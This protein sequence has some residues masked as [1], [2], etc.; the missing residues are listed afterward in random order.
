MAVSEETLPAGPSLHVPRPGRL[1]L[2]FVVAG[3][4]GAGMVV[5]AAVAYHESLAGRIL[6]GISVAGADV[7]GL[8]PDAATSLLNDRLRSLG[9]GELVIRTPDGSTTLPFAAVS[10]AA[11]VETMVAEAVA[12]GRGGTWLD[13]TVAAVRTSLEPRTIDL[14][15]GF[16]PQGVS[17]AVRAFAAAMT[18]APVDAQ[19]VKTATAFVVVPSVDGREI[20]VATTTAAVDAALAN[21]TT[22]SGFVIEAPVRTSLPRLSTA[23]AEAARDAAGRIVGTHLQ[24]RSGTKTWTLYGGRIRTWLEFGWVDGAYGPTIDQTLIPK[25]FATIGK[26]VARPVHDAALLRDKH[27]RVVGAE[28]DSAG[29]ELDVPGAVSAVVQALDDRAEGTAAATVELPLRLLVPATRTADVTRHAPLMVRVG[30]WTTYYQVSDHNGF[31]ANITVPTRTLNG[32]VV[33]PGEVFDFWRALGEV[34]FRTGYRLGGAIVGGHSVEGK[35]LA[36]GICAASTT[37]FNAALRGGYEI[38]ARQPHWYYITRYP[39]GL[40]A[41][42]SGSQTMRFRNDTRY[43]ILIRGFTGPGVVRFEI[44]SVPNGRTVTLTRPIVTNLV[45]GYDTT[46]RTATLPKGTTKRTE[47]PVDGKD[48]SVTRIVRDAAGRIVHEETYVSHYHRMVGINM[49]GIA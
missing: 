32:T 15:L 46:V 42:V 12:I 2:A 10:R 28:A 13:E 7:G 37:L 1:L 26:R 35:A 34:S 24:L 49:I 25:A 14:R 27:G 45:P 29:A 18:V 40:D 11:D 41:T 44:W 36:G 3:L 4:L 17:T 16:D 39:L 21:P 8:T 9:S 30:S 22:A 43:P 19:T 33:R 38:D 5:G 6:P 23:D 31:G 48:V 20:D 47:W